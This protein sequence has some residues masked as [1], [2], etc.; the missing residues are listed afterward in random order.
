MDGTLV[1][2]EPL[3]G[4]AT[5]ELAEILGNPLTPELRAKTVGGSFLSTLEVCAANAGKTLED[6]DVDSLRRLMF[7]RM[8]TLLGG[9]QPMSG[10][11]ELLDDLVPLPMMV[12]TNTAREL[13]DPC[14]DAVGRQYFVDSVAGDEVDRP[15][16]DPQMYLTAAQRIGVA[17]AN[18]MV[19]EDSWHGM[20]AGVSAGC[21]VIGLAEKV[22]EGATSILDLKDRI[23]LEGVNSHTLYRW[24]DRLGNRE[25]L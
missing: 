24:F 4:K 22:P 8:A 10:V 17:P 25:E 13:A 3:W 7:D 9:I 14:I 2:S 16:P 18:C 1:D 5:Y 20:S 21:V 15:K 23:S 19:F 11:R 12:V 6:I